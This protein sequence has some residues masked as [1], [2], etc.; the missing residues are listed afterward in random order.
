MTQTHGKQPKGTHPF[1]PKA[2]KKEQPKSGEDVGKVEN[3]DS[4][5]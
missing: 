5:R 2:G 4:Q 3:T 1:H